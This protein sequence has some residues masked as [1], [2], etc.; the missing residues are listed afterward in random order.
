MVGVGGGGG[1]GG[2]ILRDYLVSTQ[3]QLWLFC[4]RGCGCCWAVTIKSVFI[5]GYQYASEYGYRYSTQL[6]LS[7]SQ[8]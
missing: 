2:G 1:V 6:V 3:R 4:C 7:V 5:L 8:A